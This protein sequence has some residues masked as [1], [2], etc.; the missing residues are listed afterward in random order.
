M[1]FV[2]TELLAAYCWLLHTRLSLWSAEARLPVGVA[3]ATLPARRAHQYV[4]K[5]TCTHTHAHKQIAL[6]LAYKMGVCCCFSFV[7]FYAVLICAYAL[8]V[9]AGVGAA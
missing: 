4:G 2:L 9:V 5:R 8:V 6:A 1:S 7:L 3:A